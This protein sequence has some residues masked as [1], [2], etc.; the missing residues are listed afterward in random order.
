M[1]SV[2]EETPSDRDAVRLIHELAF[3]GPIEARLVDAIR[4]HGHQT[5]SLVT[6]QD[7]YVVGHILFSP[8]RIEN[9]G[10]VLDGMGLAP[11]AVLPEFQRRGIGAALV[12]EGLHRLDTSG[13]AFVI[14][15]GHPAYYPRFGFEQASGRGIQPPWEGI[16]EDAFFVRFRPGV[17]SARARGV[18][19]YL[20]EF[21]DAV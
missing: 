21:D 4:A 10:V 13:C 6:V 20:P 1:F 12:R 16:P 18:A 5:L 2:R 15:L 9:D 3:A 8:A 17:T 19:Y 11:I 7:D 14:V